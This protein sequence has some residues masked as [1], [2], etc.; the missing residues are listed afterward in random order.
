MAEQVSVDSANATP[1]RTSQTFPAGTRLRLTVTGGYVM[2]GGSNWLYADAEC[3]LGPERTWQSNRLSGTFNGSNQPLG[4]LAVNWSVGNWYPSDGSGSCDEADN[5]Y[6]RNVDVNTAGPVSFVVA[7]DYYGD[8][9]GSL[10]VT[11]EPR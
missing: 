5:T 11:V 4:D 3:T 1:A 9:R 6:T 2:R 10:K 7:D 8:N